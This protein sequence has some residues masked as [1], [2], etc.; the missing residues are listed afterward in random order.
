MDYEEILHYI[1][2]I[3]EEIE[4]EETTIL[5]IKSRL[6]ELINRIE[7]NRGMSGRESEEFNFD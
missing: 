4:F 1:E 5:E 6:Q 2:D 7:N 3:V